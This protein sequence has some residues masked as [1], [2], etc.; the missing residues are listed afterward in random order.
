VD[1][2]VSRSLGWRSESSKVLVIN[3]DATP[4]D[5]DDYIIYNGVYDPSWPIAS[6]VPPPTYM[7]VYPDDP[8]HYSSDNLCTGYEYPSY[9]QAAR[10][11]HTYQAKVLFILPSDATTKVSEKWQEINGVFEQPSDYVITMDFDEPSAAVQK[12]LDLLPELLTSACSTPS[13]QFTTEP[14]TN[15]TTQEEKTIPVTQQSTAQE[16][17]QEATETAQ[18]TTPEESSTGDSDTTTTTGDSETTTTTGES[19]TTTTTTTTAECRPT[20]TTDECRPP[21]TTPGECRPTETTTCKIATTYECQPQTI[22]NECEDHP[23]NADSPLIKLI[24]L[25]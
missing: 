1:A 20:T 3:T 15:D 8:Q 19:E 10:V 5:P 25:S 23:A 18:E 2:T 17:T 4:H 22:P 13:P 21:T 12:L 16:T 14:T 6:P 11:A 9:E 24:L 7:P